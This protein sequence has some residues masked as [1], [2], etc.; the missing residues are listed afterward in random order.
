MRPNYV[1]LSATDIHLICRLEI[2][3]S[4]N[5]ITKFPV[6]SENDFQFEGAVLLAK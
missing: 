2:N 3:W 1:K 5:P 6:D 4:T